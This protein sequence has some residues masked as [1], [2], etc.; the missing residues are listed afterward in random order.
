MQAI[1]IKPPLFDAVQAT[2]NLLEYVCA[3][4]Y[5]TMPHHQLLKHYAPPTATRPAAAPHAGFSLSVL[6]MYHPTTRSIC[7]GARCLYGC[8]G[9]PAELFLVL[10]ACRTR[11]ARVSGCGFFCITAGVPYGR[12][13]LYES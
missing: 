2:Y 5:R 8:T 9:S 11:L 13:G 12:T 7:S 10:R 1:A 6:Y 4:L 3:G